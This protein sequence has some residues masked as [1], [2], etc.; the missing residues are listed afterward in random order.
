MHRG[1]LAGRSSKG[2]WGSG[3]PLPGNQLAFGLLKRGRVL[4]KR[5]VITMVITHLRGFKSP[6]WVITRLTS[7]LL[8]ALPL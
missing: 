5:V 2:L 1:C 4:S 8:G 6:K 7:H 3:S